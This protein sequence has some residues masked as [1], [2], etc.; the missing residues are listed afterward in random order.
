VLDTTGLFLLDFAPKPSVVQ[1]V[2]DAAYKSANAYF[3]GDP[4]SPSYTVKAFP[5]GS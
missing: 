3:K 2:G 4:N 5:E 1:T